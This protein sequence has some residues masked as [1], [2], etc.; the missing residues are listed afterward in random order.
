MNHYTIEILNAD[1]NYVLEAIRMRGHALADQIAGQ[2]LRAQKAEEAAKVRQALAQAEE[3]PWSV[4]VT[5][6]NKM[7][8]EIKAPKKR[9]RPAKKTDA[10]PWGVKKDGTPKKRPGRKTAK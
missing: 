2:V 6:D 9:G 8:A 3:S 4:S 1:I 5:D 7:V 10:A